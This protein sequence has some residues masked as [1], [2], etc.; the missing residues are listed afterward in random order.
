MRS[1]QVKSRAFPIGGGLTRRPDRLFAQAPVGGMC[2]VA[3]WQVSQKKAIG[4]A[5]TVPI[6]TFGPGAA[7][8][9]GEGG[10]Q[11]QNSPHFYRDILFLLQMAC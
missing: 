5:G 3:I 7:W 9:E 8:T 10:M 4:F 11:R 2:G 1:A 6:K